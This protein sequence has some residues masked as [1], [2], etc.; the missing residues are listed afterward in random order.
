MLVSETEGPAIV[1]LL[2]K[3]FENNQLKSVDRAREW[4]ARAPV[5]IAWPA[6]KSALPASGRLGSVRNGLTPAAPA[7]QRGAALLQGAAERDRPPR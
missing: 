2:I 4:C 5:T 7:P 3:I 1:T 6:A